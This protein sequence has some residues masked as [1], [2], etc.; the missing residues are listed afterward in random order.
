[1]D[2]RARAW[3]DRG[4]HATWSA[5]GRDVRVFHVECGPRDAP[6]VLLVHGFPTSS[7]DWC[8]VVD[9][10]AER[11]RVACLDF[12]GYG[13]SD[14]P[15]D[16]PYSISLDA[17][18]LHHYV[19]DVLGASRC[20]V[21]AHD[22]GDSV[23]LLLHERIVRGEV[24]GLALD[25]LVLANGNIFLPLANLT[26]FQKRVLDPAG[27]EAVR[28]LVTADAL[29]QGMGASTFT[30]SR[31]PDDPTVAALATTFA[32]A[33][34]TAVLHDTIQYLRERAEHEVTWLRSLATSDVPTTVVWGMCD[35]VSPPRVAT[36]VWE[37]YVRA[38]P[39][40]N[41]LWLVP[42]ANHYL[43]NDRPDAF[44]DV[45]V[46]AFER[47]GP[48]PPGPVGDGPGAPVRIDHSAARLPDATDVF[49]I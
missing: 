32:F 37:H 28:D 48:R 16:W 46:R 40:S 39:G 33:D 26:E 24:D 47:T 49:A 14:K 35:T 17:Q 22:R 30:P 2:D 10:L 8:D 12:P 38:K 34:G 25:H 45:V 27:W 13:F 7:I 6:L 41:E 3:L 19:V 21:V 23:A 44:V 43:Q 4:S 5:G 42:D 1:M 11:Y 15:P 31:G 18:L 9:V 36:H 29:A 20:R